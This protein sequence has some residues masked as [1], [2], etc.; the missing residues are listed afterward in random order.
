MDQSWQET[1]LMLASIRQEYMMICQ[2]LKH[3]TDSQRAIQLRDMASVCIADYQETIRQ[4][5]AANQRET[6]VSL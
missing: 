3:T 6:I 5:R 4:Y 2:E 1:N